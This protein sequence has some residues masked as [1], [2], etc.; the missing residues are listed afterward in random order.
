MNQF[1]LTQKWLLMMLGT[2]L[3]GV[4]MAGCAKKDAGK[5]PSRL[6]IQ[7]VSGNAPQQQ[8]PNANPGNFPMQLP[9]GALSQGAEADLKSV[10]ATLQPTKVAYKGNLTPDKAA[11]I[12]NGVARISLNEIPPKD[13]PKDPKVMNE[14]N[15]RIKQKSDALYSQYGTNMSEVMRYISSLTGKDREAYNKKLTDLF[16]EDSKRKAD[17]AAAA[18]PRPTPPLIPKFK[19]ENKKANKD[20]KTK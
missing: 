16:L 20:E 4:C 7:G 17:V 6:G 12:T 9:Q 14:I 2:L 11:E 1:T 5:T 19:Q 13:L 3:L 15:T 10:I 18:Q 8:A